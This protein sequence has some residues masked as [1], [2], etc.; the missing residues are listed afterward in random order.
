M[1]E[2]ASTLFLK[3]V[4]VVIGLAVLAFCITVIPYLATANIRNVPEFRI[5]FYPALAGL[6]L[7]ALP[8]FF[9]LLQAFRLLR[10]I[11]RHEAFSQ[12]AAGALR[13]ITFSA[14]AMAAFYAL[15]L[16]MAVVYAEL[17]D[18]PG[19]II[20]SFAFAGAPLV[21]ATFAAVLQKL[22]QSAAAMKSEQD[23]TV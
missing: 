18:A 7:S 8:F 16:P 12:A 20:I 11:D 19:L 22:V 21:V 2:R 14:L 3:T 9:A 17:D 6:S 4:I 15:C 1:K 10:L 23:L 5:V 13:R